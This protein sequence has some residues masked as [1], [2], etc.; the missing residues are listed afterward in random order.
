MS[1]KQIFIAAT[2]LA[3]L[4]CSA[5]LARRAD[6]PPQRQRTVDLELILAVDVSRSM[7]TQ[8]LKLQ[9]EGYVAA[10]RDPGV[11]QAIRSGP[12]GRIAVT[13]VEWS[14]SDI[15]STIVPWR[16]L[17]SHNDARAFA[18]DLARH[19]T[20]RTRRTSI[21]A[22]LGRAGEM[23]AVSGFRALRRVVDISGD[24]PNNSGPPV[25]Q[26]R[27]SLVRQ[28]VIINGLPIMAGPEEH[29][30]PRPVVKLDDYYRDCV[31]GGA[32]AFFIPVTGMRNFAKAVRMKLILEIAARPP[33]FARMRVIKAGLRTASVQSGSTLCNNVD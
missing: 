9:R 6:G 16:I 24:G 26:A 15:Q 22:M 23:F 32:G 25:A 14:S 10:F 33:S 31:I 19:V 11:A 4:L 2:T 3:V 28:G 20:S 12:A 1:P 5:A 30:G 13:Y 17:S 29:L 7:S 21:S 8:R 18:D 27:D